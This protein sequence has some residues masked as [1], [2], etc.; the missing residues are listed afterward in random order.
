MLQLYL[1]R[2]AMMSA[3]RNAQ[4][5]LFHGGVGNAVAADVEAAHAV[6]QRP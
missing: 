3:L 2:T 4:D 6:V 1:K 5:H